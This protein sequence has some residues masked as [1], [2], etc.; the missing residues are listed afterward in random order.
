MISQLGHEV[1]EI[2][3]LRAQRK[4]RS[5][6]ASQP[7]VCFAPPPTLQILQREGGS[8][9]GSRSASSRRL[10][11]SLHQAALITMEERT[12]INL[13]VSHETIKLRLFDLIRQM[14]PQE[15]NMNKNDLEL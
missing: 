14:T 10:S 7:R 13:D 15:R 4:Q 12:L 1:D 6:D 8:R 5:E 2:V 9:L 11:E 3:K